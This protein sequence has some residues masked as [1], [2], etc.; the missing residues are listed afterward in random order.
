MTKLWYLF[1]GEQRD[2]R[3]TVGILVAF[4]HGH[5]SEEI[6]LLL[7]GE[8]NDFRVT[9]HDDGVCQLVA[10]QPGLRRKKQHIR[11]VST[12]TWRSASPAES[13]FTPSSPLLCYFT[14]T[15]LLIYWLICYFYS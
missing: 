9:K 3:H 11:A 12:Q 2:G 7:A 15:N 14:P 10:E 13:A 6:H 5:L 8:E 4:S 1:S